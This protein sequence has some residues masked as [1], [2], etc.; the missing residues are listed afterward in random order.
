MELLRAEIA[1]F[2][3]TELPGVRV[4]KKKIALVKEG[5][6]DPKWS[7]L[8]PSLEQEWQ[9]GSEGLQSRELLNL[10]WSGGIVAA[11][12]RT[13]LVVYQ[14][15]EHSCA[16]VVRSDFGEQGTFLIAAADQVAEDVDSAVLKELLRTNGERFGL[17]IFGGPPD[18]WGCIL[19][20]DELAPI[21]LEAFSHRSF[22]YSEA[23]DEEFEDLERE[24]QSDEDESLDSEAE[25]DRVELFREYLRRIL[26]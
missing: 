9:Q 5:Y 7:S 17:D 22:H 23:W 21:L 6:V 18:S 10:Y 19:T 24:L 4:P 13:A 3:P 20:P 12:S 16:Y 1:K 26:G 14:L 15:D 11:P 8:V 2:T 25:P